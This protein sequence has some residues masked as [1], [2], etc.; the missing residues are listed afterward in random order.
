MEQEMGY[1]ALVACVLLT[2]H[3]FIV[4]MKILWKRHDSGLKW[5]KKMA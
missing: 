5:N 2:F 1:V 4:A 3:L